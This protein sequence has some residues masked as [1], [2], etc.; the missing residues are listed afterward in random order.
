MQSKTDQEFYKTPLDASIVRALI[1]DMDGVLWRGDQPIG[2]LPRIFAYIRAQGWKV[3][4]ATNNAT[5][6]VTQYLDKLMSFG[7]SLQPDEIVNSSQAAAH[8]LSRNYP[9]GGKVYIIGENGLL[10]TLTNAGFTPV[11]LTPEE[12]NETAGEIVSVVVGMDR[13]V[14][15]NDLTVATRLIRSGV[16]F[17]GTNPDRTFPTPIGLV[18]GAGAI[19]AAIE[20]ATDVRPII[21]GKPSPEMYQVALERMGVDPQH[22]LVAGDR[23]ETDIAGGQ[24]IGCLTALVLSGVTTPDEASR[25]APPP[26]WISPDLE[27]LLMGNR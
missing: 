6:S 12:A 19:L 18:P 24:A 10:D 4:L 13:R 5:L 2:D 25:W 14:T 9:N 22:T 17:I 23:L 1:L 7:V 26:D 20:T 8:Y 11:E 16:A 3:C 21:C 15:Y 27:T